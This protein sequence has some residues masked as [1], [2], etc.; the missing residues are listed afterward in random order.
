MTL[1]GAGVNVPIN[2]RSSLNPTLGIPK[3]KRGT[4]PYPDER[5]IC[6]ITHK[7]K[8]LRFRTNPNTIRWTRKLNRAIDNTYGGR[9]I[10]LL[11]ASIDDLVVKAD[12]GRGGWEYK[13]EIVRFMRDLLIDQRQ[14]E[15]ATFE[16]NTR[17]WVMK[18]YA[19]SVPFSDEKGAVLR[20]FELNFKVQEDVSGVISQATLN[21]E[22]ARLQDGIGWHKSKYNQPD[23]SSWEDGEN[24][25]LGLGS[26]QDKIS[27]VINQ[28]Q[29]VS[30][31]LGALNPNTGGVGLP[32]LG[33]LG[34]LLGAK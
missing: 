27:D 2:P 23:S 31:L 3:G 24:G 14:G 22:L 29:N 12:C 9:V 5:G 30:G 13:Q 18:V 4:Q 16:Y 21:S 17:G 26:V 28:I 34:S 20:E 15:P 7:G 11:S 10:Q 1:P 33:N 6:S 8:T 25:W 32:G 19:T